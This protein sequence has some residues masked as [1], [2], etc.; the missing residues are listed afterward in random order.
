MDQLQIQIQTKHYRDAY[1]FILRCPLELAL[2]ERFPEAY[3]IVGSKRVVI[4]HNPTKDVDA[5]VYSISDNYNVKSCEANIKLA[6]EGGVVGSTVTLTKTGVQEN[7]FLTPPK[8]DHIGN[9]VEINALPA[10]LFT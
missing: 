8:D 7:Y 5:I 6:K 4:I 9:N 3:I 1:D 2:K 10:D